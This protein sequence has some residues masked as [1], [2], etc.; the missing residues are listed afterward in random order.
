MFKQRYI[1]LNTSYLPT[2]WSASPVY[3]ALC[4]REWSYGVCV[5]KR[6]VTSILITYATWRSNTIREKRVKQFIWP[7]RS[8]YFLLKFQRTLHYATCNMNEAGDGDV[9]HLEM[10]RCSVRP[11][12]GSAVNECVRATPAPGTI[13]HGLPIRG[14][15]QVVARTLQKPHC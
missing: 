6:I 10:G 5:W 15:P 14:R 12:A 1:L 2:K 8:G 11:F 3:G 7:N 4:T 9:F 13:A